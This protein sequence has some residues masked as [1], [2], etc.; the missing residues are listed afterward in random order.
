MAAMDAGEDSLSSTIGLIDYSAA[1]ACAARVA[2]IDCDRRN[3]GHPRLIGD[4]CPK[5]GKGP[6]MQ[7]VALALPGP[8]PLADVRQI[9]DG[10]RKAVAFSLRNNLLA[11]AVVRVPAKPALLAG[12][13][14]EAPLGGLGTK[15]L[16]PSPAFGEPRPDALDLG[17]GVRVPLAVER[18]VD[19]S[20]V[21][22]QHALDINLGRVRHV[23]DAGEIPFAAHEH[24]IDFA[25]AE[26]QQCPL[27]VAA[28]ERDYLPPVKRPDA[29]PIVGQHTKDTVI[30]GLRRVLAEGHQA[31]AAIGL[32]RRVSICH[33]G[34]GAHD[35]LR[36]EIKARS[37][38]SVGKLVQIELSRLA[39]RKATLR[40]VIA[41]LVAALKRRAQELFLRAR[42]P[43]L[44][45]GNEFHPSNMECVAY[46]VNLRES[47]R[48]NARTSLPPRPKRR[49]FSEK[50]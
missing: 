34:D 7:P 16:Q 48:A 9:L 26:S 4:E 1:R 5:L 31:V 44:D 29:H 33:L 28:D 30:V 2:R 3:T 13:F 12:Q 25:L 35:D 18:Q 6:T 42:R 22:A 49:G 20:E 11:D 47:L 36:R 19:D 32:L 15:A 8:N 21:N 43:Q 23:A 37:G 38:L 27:A 50:N 39:R 10:N 41:S 14:L 45:V 17:A 40:Q 46:N 24:Q